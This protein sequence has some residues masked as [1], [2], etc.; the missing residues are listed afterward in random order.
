ME[1]QGR[2]KE[3]RSKGLNVA[4]ISYDPVAVL[5]DFA[6]RRDITFPLLSDAGS[7]TITNYGILNTTE[8]STSR[9]RGVPF[10][11]TFILDRRAIVTARFFEQNYQER[12]T[13]ASI[14]T[15]LGSD[16]SRSAAL[17]SAPSLTRRP[18]SL[19][20]PVPDCSSRTLSTPPHRITTSSR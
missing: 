1:L 7:V 15:R 9:I 14:L 16:G 12:E 10:P 2:V 20:I 6:R 8:A 17:I 5:A 18:H 19:S 13:A 3:L 4:A 11:G